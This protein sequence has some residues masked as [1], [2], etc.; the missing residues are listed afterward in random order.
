MI[1]FSV[2]TKPWPDKS[3]PELAEFVKDMGFDGIELP[4]RPGYQVTPENMRDALPKAVR[5]FEKQGLSILSVTGTT[6]N[7]V[8]EDLI[9][10]CGDNDIPVLRIMARIDPAKGY[11]HAEAELRELYGSMIPALEGNGVKIGVQNHHGY[12]IGSAIGLKHFLDPLQSEHIGYV[13]DPAH[14]ALAGE[15]EDLAID[16]AW[17]RMLMVNLKNG[18]RRRVN[19]PEADDVEWKVYWTDGSQGFCSWPRTVELLQKRNY[20]GT[21]CLHA[22]YSDPKL[23]ESLTRNDLVFARR[24]FA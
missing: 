16:I 22:E 7:A 14:C 19:G 20:A 9:R 11:L 15:P 10:L 23:V 12:F 17:D 6:D 2:F 8:S 21:V 3:L 4:V 5:E 1:N 24:L 18:F 13:L